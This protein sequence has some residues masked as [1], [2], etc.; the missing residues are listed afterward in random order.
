LEKHDDSRK[1]AEMTSVPVLKNDFIINE[2]EYQTCKGWM[3]EA[4]EETIRHPLDD[5]ELEV[6]R[7][8]IKKLVDEYEENWRH[9]N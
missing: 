7:R 5:P 4:N 2:H 1:A 6:H 9:G 8:R 3:A